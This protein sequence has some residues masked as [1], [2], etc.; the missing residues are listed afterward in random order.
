MIQMTITGAKE[1]EAK[2]VSLEKKVAKSIVR[3]AVRAGAKPIHVTA[4]ANALNAVGGTMGSKISRALAVRAFRRQRRGQYGVNVIFKDDPMLIH[5][6]KDGTRQ[7]IPAAIEYGHAFPGRGG[8]NAPKDVPARPYMRP[9]FDSKKG[10]AERAVRR[11]LLAGIERA[12]N[13]G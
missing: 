3:K 7:Y 8:K 1:I 11:E 2:L 6:T 5:I 4:K 9:A 10:E 12:G 13:G